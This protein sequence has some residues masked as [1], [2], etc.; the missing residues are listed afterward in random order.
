MR[1]IRFICALV[2]LAALV[3]CND[4]NPQAA[5]SA[6]PAKPAKKEPMLYAGREAFQ[7]MYVSAHMWV[8]DAR[9]YLL[10][11]VVNAESNGH[12]GRASVWRGGFAS[13]SRHGLKGFLWSGSQLPEAPSLG[14]SSGVEDMYNP[15][16]SSTQAFDIGFLK[17]D[18]DKAYETALKHGGDKLIK[19]N[20][21]QSVAYTL[22]WSPHENIL[23]WHV[24][25]GTGLQDAKLRIAVNASTGEYI[26]TE[27]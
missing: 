1:S 25:F 7:K 17:I 8:P 14:I 24:I 10:E 18:S 11:S 4:N 12:D 20:P 2:F 15:S 16:N 9:P 21:N 22:G 23:T 13:L 26:R 19:A 27:M 6:E 5:K 3:A